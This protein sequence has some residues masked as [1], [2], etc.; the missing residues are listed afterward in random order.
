MPTWKQKAGNHFSW[1]DKF[2]I[3]AK[4][5]NYDFRFTLADN[6]SEITRYNNP[7]KLLSDYYEGQVIGEIWGYTTEGF[8]IDQAD[9][10]SMRNRARK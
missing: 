4:P 7:D 6:T 3:A 5:L 8:F 10:D 1:R 9:V 2:N